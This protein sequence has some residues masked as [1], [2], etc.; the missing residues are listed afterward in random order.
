MLLALPSPNEARVQRGAV[1]LCPIPRFLRSPLSARFIALFSPG[2][3]FFLSWLLIVWTVTW[4][5]VTCFPLWGSL[6]WKQSGRRVFPSMRPVPP[7]KASA[8]WMLSTPP[9]TGGRVSLVS[10]VFPVF[11]ESW[12]DTADTVNSCVGGGHSIG[13]PYPCPLHLPYL[14][15]WPAPL[16]RVVPSRIHCAITPQ[17]YRYAKSLPELWWPFWQQHQTK[18]AS[19]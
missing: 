15:Q 1:Y 6:W 14:R 12:V 4:I 13:W 2:I 3:L 17:V 10:F 18:L 8:E 16:L 5:Y 11:S 19:M 7:Y 9:P